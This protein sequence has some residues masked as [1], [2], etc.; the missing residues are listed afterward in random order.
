MTK[1]DG[2]MLS[3]FGWVLAVCTA[4]AAETHVY[5]TEARGEMREVAANFWSALSQGNANTVDL[6]AAAPGHAFTGLGVS[7][8]E[9][10]CYLLSRLS[11]ERRAE[12]LRT[13]CSAFRNPDGSQVVVIGCKPAEGD[14]FLPV[15]VQVKY[16]NRYLIGQALPNALTTVVVR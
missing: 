7:I 14:P 1:K 11:A 16:R 10:S 8:P 4:A 6:D 9:A 13:V 3:G 2:W 12:I 15:Q 5:R